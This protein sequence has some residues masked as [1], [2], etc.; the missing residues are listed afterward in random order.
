[1]AKKVKT[2]TTVTTVTEEILNE[3][4]HLICIL[5]RSGS[6]SNIMSDSI[7]GFNTFL[8]QQK[9]LPD[10]ATITVVL[11]DDRYEMIYDNVDIKKA[12][13]LTDKVWFARGTTAL[14]DAIGKTINTEKGNFKKLGSEKPSKVLCCIVTDGHENASKE[15]NDNAIKKLIK[16]CEDESW[17]FI[18]LAANQIASEVGNSFGISVG[19]T[20]TYTTNSTGISNMSMNMSNASASYRSMSSLDGDFKKRSKNLIDSD[21]D[22]NNFNINST[23][24][25]TSVGFSG[26]ATTNSVTY[27]K[28]PS[29]NTAK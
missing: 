2:T 10:E 1:M 17:S 7:G 4:T 14:Y 24:S 20:Y 5:D 16:S 27:A 25:A 19:N 8:K 26:G 15:Y 11:F 23:G 18:Y 3:K 6:M 13:E 28:A 21:V 12:E 22:L 9:E 29:T